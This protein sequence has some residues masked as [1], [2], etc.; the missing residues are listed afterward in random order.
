MGI[1]LREAQNYVPKDIQKKK[2]LLYSKVCGDISLPTNFRK[3]YKMCEWNTTTGFL[4]FFRRVFFFFFIFFRN[5]S[6]R[7]NPGWFQLEI[8]PNA[9]RR[10]TILQKQFTTIIVIIEI[11]HVF[12]FCRLWPG[13]YSKAYVTLSDHLFFQKTSIS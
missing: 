12:F 1:K 10:S 9:F 7:G 13:I 2:I 4:E 11:F 6:R 5:F 8:R 3:I